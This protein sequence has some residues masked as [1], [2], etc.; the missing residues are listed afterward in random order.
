MLGGFFFTLLLIFGSLP[1][2]AATNDFIE[3][4]DH[5]DVD[6]KLQEDGTL[7][8][9]EVIQYDFDKFPGH[10]IFRSIP[11]R[12]VRGWYNDNLEIDLLSVT[13]AQEQEHPVE[14]VKPDE[15]NEP[16]GNVVWRIGSPGVEVTGRQ[17][18]VITYTAK[19]VIERFDDHDELYWN[20]I[21]D[22]WTVAIQSATATLHLPNSLL[23]DRYEPECYTGYYGSEAQ[24]CTIKRIDTNIWQIEAESNELGFDLG[25]GQGMTILFALKR[26]EIPEP[27]AIQTFWHLA[28]SNWSLSFLPLILVLLIGLALRAKPRQSNK[29]LI[30]IYE[31]PADLEAHTLELVLYN[32]LSDKTFAATLI[33][34]ARDGYVHFVYN[35]EKKKVSELKKVK[36]YEGQ[37][38]VMQTV[39][40]RVFGNKQKIVLKDTVIDRLSLKTYLTTL[41]EQEIRSRGWLDDGLKKVQTWLSGLVSLLVVAAIVGTIYGFGQY[42][43]HLGITSTLVGILALTMSVVKRR[44]T[45]LTAQGAAIKKEIE[46]FKWFLRVTE[47]ERVKFSNAPKLT[48]QLFEAYLPY[49]VVLGVEKE[50][51]GQFANVLKEPPS[52]LEGAPY[53]YVYFSRALLFTGH[54]YSSFK[55]PARPSGS[56]YRGGSGFSSGGG[57]SGGGFGGGGGGRW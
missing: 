38:R 3:E 5:Y 11:Y 34:L 9:Q 49:A 35:P 16:S 42:L 15:F 10:G 30:P 12:Y 43:Y 18:Y 24:D 46:G 55:S 17:T 13:N 28:K 39:M 27:S 14:K 4:I 41:D 20:V 54:S 19:W 23:E 56:Y 26:G 52:W 47:A 36:D 53:G 33:E 51:V 8:I 2:Q 21:G 25:S 7:L 48:P 31:P 40:K 32:K 6:I 37:D 45:S 1:A 44:W 57:F 29:P 22:Q 50:W